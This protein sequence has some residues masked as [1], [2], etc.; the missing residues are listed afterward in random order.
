MSSP[1]RIWRKVRNCHHVGVQGVLACVAILTNNNILTLLLVCVEQ[2]HLSMGFLFRVHYQWQTVQAIATPRWW[3]NWISVLV[4]WIMLDV[5][6]EKAIYISYHHCFLVLMFMCYTRVSEYFSHT[7]Q[8][9]HETIKM[10]PE[11]ALVYT[12]PQSVDNVC[13]VIVL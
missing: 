13:I 5:I 12:M 4:Y 2:Q 7:K 6:W 3:H 9:E 10:S 8:S 1:S 11:L